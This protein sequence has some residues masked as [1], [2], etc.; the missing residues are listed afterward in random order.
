MNIPVHTLTS[1]KRLSPKPHLE[2]SIDESKSG[3]SRNHQCMLC[4]P[5]NTPIYSMSQ[6]SQGWPA[7]RRGSGPTLPAAPE[8]RPRLHSHTC[9][10]RE[11]EEGKHGFGQLVLGELAPISVVQG[12]RSAERERR[13]LPIPGYDAKWSSAY[14]PASSSD[15]CWWHWTQSSIPSRS[16]VTN[17][18]STMRSIT[19]LAPSTS[20][21]LWQVSQSFLANVDGHQP[22]VLMVLFWGCG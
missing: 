15:P 17:C 1:T 7:V 12:W 4:T 5:L 18:S 14:Q 13:G 8:H 22:E 3:Y 21:H 19:S 6:L 10:P 2:P 20:N 11:E 9:G 16:Q